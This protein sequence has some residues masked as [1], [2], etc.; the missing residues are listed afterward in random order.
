[1][2]SGAATSS[3]S[4]FLNA[5]RL[6]QHWAYYWS[7]A[8]GVRKSYSVKKLQ[9]GAHGSR[10]TIRD[11][12]FQIFARV[13]EVPGIEGAFDFRVNGAEG[14]GCGGVPPRFFSETDTVLATDDATHL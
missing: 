6:G 8:R 5:C 12:P 11:L 2:G 14:R 4:D 3:G 9:C 13:K 1:M 7:L 10:V